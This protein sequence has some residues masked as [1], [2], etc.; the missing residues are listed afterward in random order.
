MANSD[1]LDNV[2][3]MLF[4]DDFLESFD[5]FAADHVAEFDADSE[6]QK[7]SYTDI[8]NKFTALYEKKLEEAVTAQGISIETFFQLCQDAKNNP[9]DDPMIADLVN[10]LC[11]FADYDVFI[12]LMKDKARGG[13]M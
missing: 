5:R 11:A 9:G 6:E 4:S 7:L 2:A 12:A 8:Y 10:L 13:H 3:A 1:A